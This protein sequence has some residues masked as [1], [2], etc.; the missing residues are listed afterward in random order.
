MEVVTA[1]CCN[2]IVP[3][4]SIFVQSIKASSQADVFRYAATS[5]ALRLGNNIY[6]LGIFPF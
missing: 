3:L 2:F 4:L 5:K 1:G 6:E